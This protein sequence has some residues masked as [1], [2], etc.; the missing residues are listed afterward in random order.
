MCAPPPIV[1]RKRN[2]IEYLKPIE[3]AH[4][5][6]SR[7][8][9]MLECIRAPTELDHVWIRLTRCK[10]A[11]RSC[12][13]CCAPNGVCIITLHIMLM[14]AV[15]G[16]MKLK[17]REARTLCTPRRTLSTLDSLASMCARIR[18][19]KPERLPNEMNYFDGGGGGERA[20]HALVTRTRETRLI[21]THTRSY[22]I[23]AR[24]FNLHNK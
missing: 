5:E 23:R 6:M 22:R 7:P 21:H 20:R 10:C 15:W 16:E 4:C 8:T 14:E 24:C 18:T 11:H 19:P 2:R 9:S 3:Y 1:E 12:A 17:G 13:L